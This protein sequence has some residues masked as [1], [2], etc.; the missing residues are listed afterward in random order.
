M[1]NIKI[2][3]YAVAIVSVMLTGSIG[4]FVRNI[5]LDGSIVTFARLGLG[6]VFLFFFLILKKKLRTVKIR[7]FSYSL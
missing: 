6:L 7:K 2:I 3:G 1:K 4:I 5:L